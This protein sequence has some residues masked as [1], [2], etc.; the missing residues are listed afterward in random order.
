MTRASF[1]TA[2][3]LALCFGAASAQSS[4]DDA[5]EERAAVLIEDPE[6]GEIEYFEAQGAAESEIVSAEEMVA[7]AEVSAAM[8]REMTGDMAAMPEIAEEAEW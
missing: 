4:E 3:A 8:E 1:I 5:A 7:E 6:E 2:A